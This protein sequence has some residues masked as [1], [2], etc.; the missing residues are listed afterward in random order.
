MFGGLCP[1]PIRLGGRNA[2]T[3]WT[4]AQHAALA[5]DLCAASRALPFARLVV[6]RSGS[7]VT[8]T[9]Y[10]GVNGDSVADGPTV[11]LATN[12][13]H[14]VF[15]LEWLDERDQRRSVSFT[16]AV[17]TPANA[18]QADITSTTLN[19]SGGRL[20]VSV[21]SITDGG[22]VQLTVWGGYLDRATIADYGGATDKDDTVTEVI[23]YAATLLGMLRD[24]R[25]SGYTKDRGT[26]VH[27]ENLALSRAHAATWRRSERLASN[28]NPATADEKAEDWQ[29]VLGVRP[30][31]GDTPATLRARNAAKMAM[32][33]GPT[34]EAVD[35]AIATL[36]GPLYVRTWR[37]GSSDTVADDD[38][39]YW[40]GVNPGAPA[41]DLGGGS[42]YSDRSHIVVEVTRATGVTDADFSDA[43]TS[44]VEMLDTMLPATCTFCWV[45]NADDG[46]TLDEDLLDE[47][48]VGP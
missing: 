44:L 29:K 1:L 14:V 23:P 27:V 4:S 20:R 43:M 48:C 19:A 47:A 35:T 7:A 37:Y 13:L 36:L 38:G 28:A 10:R 25:G 39:T 40:P 33:R 9:R 12:T 18:A 45:T 46:F 22:A 34:Q 15:P 16:Q 6:T 11:T 2:L 26:L 30:I 24:A 31:D 17:A 42:W 3:S 41:Y 21:A 32:V 5:R 8:V